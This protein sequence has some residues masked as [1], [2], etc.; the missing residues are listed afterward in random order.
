MTRVSFLLK[1]SSPAA[2][3][4]QAMQARAEQH[5]SGPFKEK[6]QVPGGR[7]DKADGPVVLAPSVSLLSKRK[8]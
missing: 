3:K 5:Q 8:G 2:G 6:L 4:G 7:Q 1:G